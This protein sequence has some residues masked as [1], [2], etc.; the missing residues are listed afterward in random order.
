MDPLFSLG[1]KYHR[2]LML[3][4]G[5]VAVVLTVLLVCAEQLGWWYVAQSSLVILILLAVVVVCELWESSHEAP[6]LS[7]EAKIYLRAIHRLLLFTGVGFLALIINATSQEHWQNRVVARAV[8][9]G[10]LC[11]GAFFVLGV[12]L[13][14][15]F[16]LRPTGPSQNS[17]EK[18]PSGRASAPYTNLE[19][20]ADWFTKLILGAGLVELTRMRGPLHDF[21]D[22]MATGVD[23]YPPNGYKG[24]SA[25]ALAI[26]LFFSASGILYGYLWT[27]YELAVKEPLKVE[28]L[29]P[30]DG[31]PVEP[32]TAANEGS[33]GR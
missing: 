20:V 33:R 15:L 29:A 24:S 11:A 17:G 4:I 26:M 28:R 32:N 7:D 12:L 21:A 23:P 10:T 9:Y 22:F 25:V 2:W 27:R 1:G 19:E 31:S 8:G 5:V 30:A 18:S 6:R 13:G 14:Y 3:T 16:G